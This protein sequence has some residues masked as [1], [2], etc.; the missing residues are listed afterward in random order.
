MEV[1]DEYKKQIEAWASLNFGITRTEQRV[2]GCEKKKILREWLTECDLSRGDTE[3]PRKM[4]RMM[5]KARVGDIHAEWNSLCASME[6]KF[7][8]RIM[9]MSHDG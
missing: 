9:S 6:N 1:E 3:A 5:N 8:R 4:W 2:E 7:Y